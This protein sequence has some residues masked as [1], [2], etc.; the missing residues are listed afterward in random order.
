MKKIN[1]LTKIIKF[2]KS[3]FN[4]E[5]IGTIL[6]IIIGIII[7]LLCQMTVNA[8][9]EE[10]DREWVERVFTDYT[11]YMQI[12]NVCTMSIITYR[13]GFDKARRLS[14]KNENNGYYLFY[15]KILDYRVP[16]A[17]QSAITLAA[18]LKGNLV[19]QIYNMDQKYKPA[20]LQIGIFPLK[21][22]S[23]VMMFIDEGSK[24]YKNFIRQFKDLEIIEQLGVINYI[25]FLYTED[26]FFSKELGNRIDLSCLKSV[27]GQSLDGFRFED[28]NPYPSALQECDLSKWTCIPNLLSE[29]FS[30]K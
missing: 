23:V 4:K 10:F 14:R 13:R 20:E 19:N 9:G 27:S 18:D 15:H 8:Q 1:L 29:S 28:E 3:I 30:I 21:E 12:I 2:L 5:A 26:Y 17:F 22:K 11:T 16:V 7:E 6:T 25:M 24:R